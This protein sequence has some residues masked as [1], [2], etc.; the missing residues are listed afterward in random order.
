MN[1]VTL[2]EIFATVFFVILGSLPFL[3][4]SVLSG[5]NIHKELPHQ[6]AM[7]LTASVGLV[8]FAASPLIYLLFYLD[9]FLSPSRIEFTY[10]R[11]DPRVWP[12]VWSVSDNT[13]VP[14]I[15]GLVGFGLI[16]GSAEMLRLRWTLFHRLRRKT[17]MFA[18]VFAYVQ[19]WDTYLRSIK[20]DGLI[21]IVAGNKRIEGELVFFSS[22][23]QP[24][25]LVL[26]NFSINNTSYQQLDSEI[27]IP[28]EEIKEICVPCK[29]F[30]KDYLPEP[31]VGRSL[32]YFM[33]S[34][35]L[36]LLSLSLFL[37][38]RFI[39]NH[40]KPGWVTGGLLYVFRDTADF[41]VLCSALISVIA[42]LFACLAIL[43]ALKDYH[44][45]AALQRFVLFLSLHPGLCV[46]Y[47]GLFMLLFVSL[48]GGAIF[49]LYNFCWPGVFALIVAWMAAC[50]IFSM[51]KKRL[52][53]SR[54]IKR[55]FDSIENHHSYDG[56]VI[57]LVTKTLYIEMDLNTKDIGH[58]HSVK[59]DVEKTLLLKYKWSVSHEHL[60]K[61]FFE[62]FNR[63]ASA[64]IWKD[65]DYNIIVALRA[66]LG[67]QN[68]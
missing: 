28:S 46:S 35:G 41:Y 18:H 39:I 22:K 1:Y 27:R 49:W 61:D 68:P 31:H 30:N 66:H 37:T 26:R 7:L 25:E 23:S 65:E 14:F 29:S 16:Y 17:G 58:I 62:G 6:T 40:E 24:N 52:E 20:R 38:A 50:L 44:H 36:W 32:Y 57:E 34:I 2:T 63:L 15:L 21:T 11:I 42:L 5:Y 12:L 3:L 47:F 33:L 67:L 51:I 4:S 9:H 43:E 8:M 45:K 53:S 60:V 54:A 55:F 64:G 10:H 56:A 19:P 13:I 59:R 48:L